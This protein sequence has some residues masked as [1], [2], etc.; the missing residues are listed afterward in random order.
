MEPTNS[1]VRNVK[2]Q[3]VRD[4]S[5]LTSKYFPFTKFYNIYNHSMDMCYNAG[6][7]PLYEVLQDELQQAIYIGI[8]QFMLWSHWVSTFD[9][10]DLNRKRYWRVSF[11]TFFNI[12]RYFDY[13]LFLFQED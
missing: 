2:W 6:P 13:D 1:I 11:V 7:G 4:Y 8:L 12:Y 3:G 5:G 9:Y 10:Y